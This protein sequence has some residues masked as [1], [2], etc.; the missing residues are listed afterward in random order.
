MHD[1]IPAEC[2]GP[3]PPGLEAC[4][5]RLSDAVGRKW[6]LIAATTVFS[7]LVA[8]LYLART[9]R[10]YEATARL[11]LLQQGGRP[12]S[13][14]KDEGM[15]A[16]ERSED[17][18]PTQMAVLQSPHVVGRAI[19]AV[20]AEKFPTLRGRRGATSVEEMTRTMIKYYLKITRP[21]RS[22]S[23][24]LIKYRAASKA[25][26]TRMVEALVASYQGFLISNDKNDNSK[27]VSIISRARDELSR[28]LE[29]LEKKYLEFQRTNPLLMEDASSRPLLNSRLTALDRSANEAMVKAMRLRSQLAIGRRLASEGAETWAVA[30]AIAQVGDDPGIGLIPR[31]AESTQG[32]SAD[33]L[34]QLIKEQQELAATFGPEYS[35]VKE[36]QEQIAAVGQRTREAMGRL[37]GGEIDQ[38]LSS[39]RQSLDSVEAMR[40]E[41]GKQLQQDM[42]EARKN[43]IDMTVGRN[44]HS[45]LERQ[46][47]LFFAIVDQLK[48]AQFGGDFGS[49]GA[50]RSSGPMR[51]TSRSI[52]RC[53]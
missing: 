16:V 48:Q 26:A 4:L 49:I 25:E 24:L 42:E 14:T 51:S 8:A 18:I 6:R 32:I 43:T 28:E 40:T 46:K 20:G 39:I 52:P 33:Y 12:L 9:E 37:D 44:L 2:P 47:T 45:Q 50:R 23:I 30:Y 41:L 22:A 21:D 29:D 17:F 38:L 3:A 53:S 35:K 15:R 27:V 10:L 5:R 31:S 34:R 13:V 19:E 36:L 11:L 7:M 1:P